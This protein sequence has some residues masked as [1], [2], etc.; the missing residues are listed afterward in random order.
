MV[1]LKIFKFFASLLDYYYYIITLLYYTIRKHKTND[2]GIFK[3]GIGLQI[4]KESRN[5]VPIQINTGQLD[6][7]LLTFRQ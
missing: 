3:I 2:F 4:N 7:L 1:L 5:T 6:A